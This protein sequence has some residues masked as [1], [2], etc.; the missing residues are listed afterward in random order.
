MGKYYYAFISYCHKDSE[1]AKWLQHEF[2]YYELPAKL[3]EE[4][5]DLCR[6][7]FPQSFKPV[8]RDED[9]LAGGELKPQIS[10]A[11]T[12]SEYLIVVCSPN[13]AQ[14][15]YVDNEI[16]EFISLSPENKRRI[17]PFIVDGKPHQD[18]EHKEKEC[19]PKSLLELSNDKSDP[20]ELIGGDIDIHT[21]GRDHAFIKILAGTLREKSIRF[22][23]LWDRYAI[24]KAEKE[25][26]EREDKEKLQIAQSRFISEKA[27]QLVDEGDTYL[28]RL[29]ALEVL[30]KDLDNPNRPFVPRVEATL[31]ESIKLRANNSIAI[32]KA[33]DNLGISC[34]SFSPNGELIAA[35]VGK[36]IV[37][38]DVESGALIKESIENECALRTIAYRSD[39]KY[40]YTGDA[41]GNIGIWDV[42]ELFQIATHKIGIIA[43]S[44]ISLHPKNQ[45][46]IAVSIDNVIKML[47]MEFFEEVI[48]PMIHDTVINSVIF[49][50]DGNAIVS[51]S[52]DNKVRIWDAHMGVL[53]NEF[54]KLHE[55]SINCVSFSPDG[56]RIATASDDCTVKI[57]DVVSKNILQTFNHPMPVISVRFCLDGNK[58]IT[59]DSN[60]RI[61]TIENETSMTF[62]FTVTDISRESRNKD[63]SRVLQLLEDNNLTNYKRHI[64][65]IFLHDGLCSI[66]I[67]PDGDMFAC[68]SG[69]YIRLCY[70]PFHINNSLKIAISNDFPG[71]SMSFNPYDGTEFATAYNDGYLR[72]YKVHGL[73][74]IINRRTMFTGHKKCIKKV[75]YSSDGQ[76]IVTS[77]MDGKIKIWNAES[78]DLVCELNGNVLEDNIAIFNP[79]DKNFILI[80][81]DNHLIFK[82]WNDEIVV[83]AYS[84]AHTKKITSIC[85]SMNGEF[86][87]SSSEDYTIKIWDAKTL[88]CLKTFFSEDSRKNILN[89]IAISHDGHKIIS[90]DSWGYIKMWDID[91]AEC[92]YTIIGHNNGIRTLVFDKTDN[93]FLSTAYDNTIKIWEVTKGELIGSYNNKSGDFICASFCLEKNLILALSDDGY[94]YYW[95][96]LPLTTIMEYTRERFKNR[97]L[98]SEERKKFYLD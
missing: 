29:L 94:I 74:S 59:L 91:K 54:K 1:M 78:L 65:T 3:F 6:E 84:E 71:G 76:N 26:K 45:Q 37:V 56:T 24:E 16:K 34:V 92:V 72:I 13:S 25:R 67:S 35:C 11:L 51:V 31:R 73:D 61:W 55:E 44:S 33:K 20:V 15:K 21:T 23:D 14:S 19:F 41:N 47:D 81:E 30:P 40:I 62:D 96:F 22:A 95:Q 58:L 4:R 57:V 89:Y 70:I 63:M 86:V 60:I 66:S 46:L 80:I 53:M 27:N 42:T 12:C 79:I 87:V 49:N 77:S 85:Y 98:T 39:G 36:R 5:T 97:Q 50:P 88:K 8:F 69:R 48:D 10:E 18:D 7:D 64:K 83:S 28:A 32:L 38:W 75:A 93:Y 52:S 82:N 68:T 90:G 2:E 43:I 17:F 9:E